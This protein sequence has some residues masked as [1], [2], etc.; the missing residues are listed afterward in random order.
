M[1]SMFISLPN[2]ANFRT[3]GQFEKVFVIMT[4]REN[5]CLI[6]RF[7]LV[8]EIFVYNYAVD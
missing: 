6:S 1:R 7:S 8:Y 5:V 3:I 2:H 4:I